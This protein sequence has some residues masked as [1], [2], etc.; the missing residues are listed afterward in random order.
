MYTAQEVL[1]VDCENACRLNSTDCR[2]SC[3]LLEQGHFAE[4]FVRAQRPQFELFAI[5]LGHS[6][7]L[8]ILDN[9]HTIARFALAD[10]YL[11]F[12]VFFPQTGHFADPIRLADLL[13]VKYRTVFSLLPS[14]FT[15]ETK[16]PLHGAF[17]ADRHIAYR[18]FRTHGLHIDAFGENPDAME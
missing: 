13:T 2:G 4:E 1:L 11:A 10:D 14:V 3:F 6:L 9:E 12:F 16:T 18:L 15:A 17:C 7:D 5:G 8:A